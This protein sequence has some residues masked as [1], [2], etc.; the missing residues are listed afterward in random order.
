MCKF[1]KIGL[2]VRGE[3]LIPTKKLVIHLSLDS[4]VLSLDRTYS[5]NLIEMLLSINM[6]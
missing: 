6:Y 5:L 4:T 1:T 3:L 2:R